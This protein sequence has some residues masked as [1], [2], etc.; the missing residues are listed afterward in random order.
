MTKLRA[1]VTDSGEGFVRFTAILSLVNDEVTFHEVLWNETFQGQTAA[2]KAVK[3]QARSYLKLIE[4]KVPTTVF[5][6][7]WELP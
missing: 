2:E 1:V 5:E 4:A 6:Q 3:M 7:E